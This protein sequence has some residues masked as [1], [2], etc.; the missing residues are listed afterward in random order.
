MSQNSL[1]LVGV[2]TEQL[3]NQKLLIKNNFELV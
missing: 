1:I 2:T 3:V